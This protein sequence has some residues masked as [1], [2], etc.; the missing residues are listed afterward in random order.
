[1]GCFGPGYYQPTDPPANDPRPDH[2]NLLIS[3]LIEAGASVNYGSSGLTSGLSASV[4][5]SNT[6]G[7]SVSR[8]LTVPDSAS[9]GIGSLNAPVSGNHLIRAA[10]DADGVAAVSFGGSYDITAVNTVP[11]ADSV[12][13]PSGFPMH[14][15]GP[16]SAGANAFISGTAKRD[17]RTVAISTSVDNPTPTKYKYIVP[18]L[19]N[20]DGD[21]AYE[22]YTHAPEADGTMRADIGLGFGDADLGNSW[23]Y[24][25][26]TYTGNPSGNWAENESQ[27]LW[28]TSLKNASYPGTLFGVP[29]DP[30]IETLT[31]AYREPYILKGTND[32]GSPMIPP[33]LAQG[34][35]GTIGGAPVTDHIFFS[36]TNGDNRP[37]PWTPY[38]TGNDG[39]GAIAK[40]SYWVY[41]HPPFELLP[42]VKHGILQLGEDQENIV[43]Q[44]ADLD[45]KAS[46]PYATSGNGLPCEWNAPSPLW[47]IADK[48]S[49][50]LSHYPWPNEWIAFG[51]GT[52]HIGIAD[53]GPKPDSATIN[54]DNVWNAPDSVFPSDHPK[55]ST[56][57]TA[58]Y[59]MTPG[60]H[61]RYLRHFLLKDDYT[62]RGF[63]GET[64]VYFDTYAGKG[65][66]FGIFKWAP[67]TGP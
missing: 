34:D 62:K 21:P 38:T 49:E 6:F 19:F 46:P 16:T 35:A 18:G 9:N 54:F 7:E 58:D 42:S 50:A 43:Y 65:P 40:A 13:G 12:F 33:L 63:Q 44:D 15:N 64:L 30:G 53:F 55:G 10:V 1:M 61:E 52:A 57:T 5:A 20:T 37:S 2:L 11:Y 56:T 36:Y 28:N 47:G 51:L 59:R 8:T 23:N 32:D 66:S 31:N 48:A 24:E 26:I 22:I 25:H 60:Q 17:D 45:I 39:D 41:I 29:P 4:S 3:T 67:P 14:S 27:Y